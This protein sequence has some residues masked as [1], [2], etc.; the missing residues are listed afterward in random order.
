[1]CVGIPMRVI[2]GDAQQALCDD[3]GVV[4]PISMM[5]VGAVAPGTHVLTHLGSA[6]RVLDPEEAKQIEDALA[7]L[8]IALEG[9]DFD[10]L[11]ADLIDREP[12]LPPHLRRPS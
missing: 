6:V 11:F 10:S 4:K 9:G 12:E 5:L 7:G 2:S 1:M 8:A 3:R